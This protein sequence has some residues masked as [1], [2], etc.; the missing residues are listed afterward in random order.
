MTTKRP[1]RQKQQ[2]HRLQTKIEIDR[3]DREI[4][5]LE[6]ENQLINRLVGR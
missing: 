1:N 6:R 5:E 3:I 4:R 2:E